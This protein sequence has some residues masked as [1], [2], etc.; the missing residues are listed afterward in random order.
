MNA[1]KYTRNTKSDEHLHNHYIRE[2][3]DVYDKHYN[4]NFT[5][6]EVFDQLYESIKDIQVFKIPFKK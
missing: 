2:I 6:E 3:K 5:W 1:V 4:S